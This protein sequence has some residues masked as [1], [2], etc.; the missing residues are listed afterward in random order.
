MLLSLYLQ[1]CHLPYIKFKKFYKSKI[2]CDYNIFL[3]LLY[4][5]HSVTNYWMLYIGSDDLTGYVFFLDDKTGTILKKIEIPT[6]KQVNY[7]SQFPDCIQ[8][9]YGYLMIAG[10]D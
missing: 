6:W 8:P 7:L 2:M 9:I 5:A 1:V 4:R 3:F 10:V